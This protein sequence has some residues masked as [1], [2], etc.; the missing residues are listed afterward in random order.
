[1]VPSFHRILELTPCTQLTQKYI[2]NTTFGVVLVT[3][4]EKINTGLH[5]VKPPSAPRQRSQYS[6]LAGQNRNRDSIPGRD[7]IFFSSPKRSYRVWG[8]R[9]QWVMD[10]TFAGG[11]ESMTWSWQP[12]HHLVPRLRMNG[13]T[14][15]LP[16][17][18]S[19]RPK[20]RLFPYIT[21]LIHETCF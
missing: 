10:G 21:Y 8:P 9:I 15:P 17:I 2:M 16:H 3:T 4:N 14:P 1:M 13:T 18:C 6:D 7:K 20:E 12:H 19:W 5:Y 11:K